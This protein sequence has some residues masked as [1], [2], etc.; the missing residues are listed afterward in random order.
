MAAME[1]IQQLADAGRQALGSATTTAE[2]EAARVAHLG[3]SA[4]L[5]LLL[6]SIPELEPA[7]RAV[8]GKDGNAARRE[9]EA[10]AASRAEELERAELE[11][12]LAT[13]R[14]DVTLPPRAMPQGSLH[15]LTQ[16]RRAIEDAF[17]GLG[18]RIVDGPEVDSEFYNF[19]AL[20]T[21]KGH[22]AWSKTDT[23]YVGDIDGE[24]LLRSQTSTLQV[25]AMQL[26]G[27]PLYAIMPGRVYRRDKLDATHSD[28]F[29]QVEGLAVDEGLTLA[30]LKGTLLAFVRALFGDER[31]IR[32]RTHF[33][34]FTE[35][36]VE[37][38]ASC[39]S[40]GGSGD[41]APG[42]DFDKCRVCRG[43]GWI[44][45]GGAGMVDPNVFGFVNESP[46][47]QE[48]G[49]RYDPARIS[50]FAFGIGID[51]TA[52]QRHDFP[53]LRMLFE[54]DVRFLAQ[55]PGR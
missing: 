55:F 9:L 8:V 7:Q 16:A 6:R 49:I 12:R 1:D 40:C 45:M 5:V 23:F 32:L 24:V 36:S 38:D 53:D 34:P 25:R 51:R 47:A 54:N 21:P 4:P 11:A 42:D 20:N 3:R 13:E 18:Y 26:Q 48:R 31:K 10:L 41:P 19:L 35:P 44:E 37:L 14:V 2:L 15:V 22:P 43:L 46:E 52:M 27:P 17:I 33:F 39:F 30:D 50:G 28:M 29:H